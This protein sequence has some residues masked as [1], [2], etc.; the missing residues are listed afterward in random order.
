M[1]EEVPDNL[2]KAELMNYT[3]PW[4]FTIP[5][6]HVIF[7]SDEQL[8]QLSNPDQ[9]VNTSLSYEPREESLRQICERAQAAGY[10]TLIMAFDHFF[11]QYRPGQGDKPRELTPD[12]DEYIEYIAKISAFAEEYGLALELSLLSPLEIGPGY[13]EETGEPGVWMHYR[14]GQRDPVTGEFSVQLWRQVRW[15]NN[16]GP[17]LLKDAGVRVFAYREQSISG[18]P[19]RMVDPDEIVEITDNVTVD[20]WDNNRKTSGQ[21]LA[22]RIRVHGEGSTDIGPLDRVLVVQ[23]YETPEMDYFSDNALP[24]LKNLVDRY[25]DAG[26]RLNALY[27]DEMHIQQD[28][29]YFS[30]HDNGEFALRYVSPG[31]EKQFAA[32]HGSQYQDLAKYMVYFTYGQEDTAN[33]LSAKDGIMH[34]WGNTPEAIHETA[35]FRARYFEL[36]QDGVVDLFV[37]AKR[38]LENKVGYK[39]ESRAHATWAESPTIDYWNSGPD[40]MHTHKYEYTSNF[41]WSNTVH[42]AASAC[43]DYFKWGEFL[44]G[45]GNDTAEGGWLDRNYWGLTVAHSIGIIN[46]VPSAYAAH[47]GM[48]NDISHRRM[49]LVNASGASAWPQYG[50][51]Q[52]MQHRDVDVL[53]LYPLDLVAMEERFG[54]WMTQY[55]YANFITQAK[56]LEL[57]KVVDGAIEMAGYRFTTLMA[58]FEPFPTRELLEMMI[59]LVDQ[60][61]KVVWSSIPPVL[62]R[63]GS[64]AQPLWQELTGVRYEPTRHHGRL[65]PGRLIQFH[66][67]LEQVDPMVVLTDFLVDRVYTFEPFEGTSVVA[68]LLDEPVG[69]Y[70]SNEK[71]GSV[72]VL[73]FRPRDDQS[74][75]MG[76]DVRY[77]FEILDAIGAHPPTG[78]FDGIN[79][80]TEHL[81]R[82]SEYLVCRFPNGAVALAPHLR[83]LVESWFGGFARNQ[84]DD[85]V[86]MER[87][88]LP[89]NEV[90]LN[91][92]KVNGHSVTYNGRDAMTFRVEDGALVAFAGAHSNEITIDGSTYRYAEQP[93][94][95][96]SWAPIE[97]ERQGSAGA[98]FQIRVHG[99]GKV[100]IPVPGITGDVEL[101]AEGSKLGSRGEVIESHLE[102]SVLT[103]TNTAATSARWLF[104]VPK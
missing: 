45:T 64:P 19:Y 72:T 3:G 16:K 15:A 85:R 55:G 101:V 68:T 89:P 44:V 41:K 93:M 24:Y 5:R 35:L 57:G 62:L 91:E 80:N 31:F 67:V 37:T 33:D 77:L 46:D 60:G 54:S 75:T 95:L 84:E 36:L 69:T 76:Y 103:F 66:D 18:T 71:G 73:G 59:A 50:M 2:Y 96:V 104:V 34:V 92:F 49:A 7:V 83:E 98:L 48:P 102:D 11:G 97:E 32:L 88:N 78:A 86:I 23:H 4:S 20:V 58:T 29:H 74:F 51:V 26:V 53:M 27:S 81:S 99:E 100:F 12:K 82:H 13:I 79:D 65:T 30:H 42:Q 14:K 22:V 63:D 9:L 94:G 25:I 70:R 1:A 8:V 38:H 43:Q 90:Q 17:L 61:G 56:L 52:N 10:R 39:V 47:W 40:S 28:W 21:Y 87:L 6:P